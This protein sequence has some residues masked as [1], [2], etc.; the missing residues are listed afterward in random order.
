M[1]IE[2]LFNNGKVLHNMNDVGP[3]RHNGKAF[4]KSLFMSK[5]FK[6]PSLEHSNNL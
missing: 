4:I 6:M 5:S 2:P 3:L 1:V